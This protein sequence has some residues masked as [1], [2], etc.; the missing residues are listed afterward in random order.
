LVVLNLTS[1][2][3]LGCYIIKGKAFYDL[4]G[5]F[6]KLY[7]YDSFQKKLGIDFLIKEQFFTVSHKDVLRGMHFQLPPY[8][9]RK[10]VTCISG[11]VL[12][13]ALDLRSNS[14]TFGKF[15]SFKL[16]GD[17]CDSVFMPIGVAHGFLSL[18]DNTIISYNT[19]TSYVQSYDDGIHWN[20]FNFKWP[21][22]NPIVSRRDDS[23]LALDKFNNP[24]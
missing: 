8:A 18:E 24:F 13:V 1:T 6:T 14:P 21:I 3:I 2:S 15:E 23:H 4:R 16:S 11:S 9:H 12:D 5:S 17:V 22:E 19:S 10:M 7:Q 20:S